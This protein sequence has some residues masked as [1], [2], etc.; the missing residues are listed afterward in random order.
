MLMATLSAGWQIVFQR[1]G[2]AVTGARKGKSLWQTQKWL[3]NLP[4]LHN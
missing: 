1:G 2:D 4:R 3:G